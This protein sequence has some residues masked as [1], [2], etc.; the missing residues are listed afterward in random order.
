[1]LQPSWVFACAFD[2]LILITSCLL[3]DPDASLEWAG[4]ARASQRRL[5]QENRGDRG[6]LTLNGE[7]TP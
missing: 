3:Y 7:P 1:M 6:V 4:I 2:M 5:R